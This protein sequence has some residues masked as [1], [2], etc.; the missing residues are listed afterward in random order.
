M[1]KVVIQRVAEEFNGVVSCT[2]KVPLQGTW[3]AVL[4]AFDAVPSTSAE[5]QVYY[6]SP[7]GDNYDVVLESDDP[8]SGD[9]VTSLSFFSD[10]PCPLPRA[11][12]I[13]VVY[14]NPDS[15]RVNVTI[16]G[17]DRPFNP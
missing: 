6:R 16:L 1:E 11:S 2:F 15:R 7:D 13:E 10:T 3:V 12:E 9:G 5:V 17:T 8:A 4:I 14:T